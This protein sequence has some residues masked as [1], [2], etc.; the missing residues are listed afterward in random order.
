MDY[1]PSDLD[2]C[3]KEID[4][5][6][7]GDD[8]TRA[9]AMSEEEFN[10]NAHFKIGMWIRN[11][12]GLWGGSKLTR[13]FN[14]MGIHHEDDMS[15]IITTSYHRHLMGEDIKLEEQVKYYQDYWEKHK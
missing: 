15:G 6:A 7:S 5:M 8:I 11:N 14:D 4:K 1:I 12:W 2:D 9:K 13:Y 3:I 10:S